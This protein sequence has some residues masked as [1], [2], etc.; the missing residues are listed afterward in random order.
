MEALWAQGEGL[1]ASQAE[2]IKMK[3]DPSVIRV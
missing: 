1:V 2:D 3:P